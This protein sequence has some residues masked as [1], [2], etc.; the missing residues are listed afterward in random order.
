MEHARYLNCKTVVTYILYFA[1]IPMGWWKSQLVPQSTRQCFTYRLWRW[2][3]RSWTLSTIFNV[4]KPHVH[5]TC[6]Q[7]VL[8]SHLLL[9]MLSGLFFHYA[10]ARGPIFLLSCNGINCKQFVNKNLV[11]RFY[12]HWMFSKKSQWKS[13]KMQHIVKQSPQSALITLQ[14]LM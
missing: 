9:I 2:R 11:L 14:K 12:V 6:L 3:W 1:G 7:D 8:I 10:L 13:F 5:L 4:W